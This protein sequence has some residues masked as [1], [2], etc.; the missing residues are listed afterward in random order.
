MTDGCYALEQAVMP[1]FM[2]STVLLFRY[3][4]PT[5]YVIRGRAG[6]K[7]FFVQDVNVATDICEQAS[8]SGTRKGHLIL[9]LRS[10]LSLS[11]RGLNQWIR[12]VTEN[13]QAV[14]VLHGTRRQ[15]VIAATMLS[16]IEDTVV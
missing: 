5:A 2:V 3:T 4:G 8:L 12:N 14:D 16:K 9:I 11:R 6:L 7:P 13:S 10:N 1:C 15:K